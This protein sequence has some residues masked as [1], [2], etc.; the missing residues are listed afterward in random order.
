MSTSVLITVDLCE[1][2]I[3]FGEMRRM[4][5]PWLIQTLS[6]HLLWRIMER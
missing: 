4:N 3:A 2:M 6:R 1:R 5:L